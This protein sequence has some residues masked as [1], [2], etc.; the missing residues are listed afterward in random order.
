[1]AEPGNDPLNWSDTAV[2]Q[3]QPICIAKFRGMPLCRAPDQ[4]IK[5]ERERERER[6]DNEF[7][8]RDSTSSSFSGASSRFLGE[9]K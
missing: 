6:K 7:R 9:L 2:G 5:R 8:V 3:L 1:M 4:T